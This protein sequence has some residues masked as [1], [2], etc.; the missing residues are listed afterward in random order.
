MSQPQSSDQKI[1]D[2]Q[3]EFDDLHIEIGSLEASK[4]TK[5]DQIK[6]KQEEIAQIQ[7]EYDECHTEI[8]LKK[9]KNF[10]T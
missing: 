9:K 8:D 7:L 5:Q 2:L 10:E 3:T 1:Q 4:I 6:A